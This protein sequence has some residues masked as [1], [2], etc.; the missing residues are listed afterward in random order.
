MGE[1]Q[2]ISPL[3]EPHRWLSIL[4]VILAGRRG[5]LLF[6]RPFCLW[7]GLEELAYVQIAVMLVF[8]SSEAG[9][10]GLPR[11]VGHNVERGRRDITAS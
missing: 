2:W 9:Q 5:E 1:T 10:K 3:D 4:R 6:E 8:P 11:F 7:A